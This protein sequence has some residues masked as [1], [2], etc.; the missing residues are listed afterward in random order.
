MESRGL[1]GFELLRKVSRPVGRHNGEGEH[2]HV[3]SNVHQSRLGRQA[4]RQNPR[5]LPPPIPF[6]DS[7]SG[8]QLYNETVT[9]ERM[10][11]CTAGD[12]YRWNIWGRAEFSDAPHYDQIAPT[13][14]TCIGH[15][16]S[17]GNQ[18]LV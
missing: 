15:A 12:N 10:V 7:P 8:L 14:T 6:S 9:A 16:V 4:N 2:V 13:A 1:R 18:L 11:T 3:C 5:N 17:I